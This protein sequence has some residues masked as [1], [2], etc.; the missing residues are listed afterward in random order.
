MSGA[1][2]ASDIC[3]SSKRSRTFVR[4]GNSRG[5]LSVLSL[6]TSFSFH[7]C[8]KRGALA[9]VLNWWI[10]KKSEIIPAELD[11]GPFRDIGPW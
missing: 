3:P 8:V 2:W 4:R 9:W 5:H 11:L 7:G 1:E 10:A 6:R